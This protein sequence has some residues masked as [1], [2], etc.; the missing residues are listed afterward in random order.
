MT[1]H[2]A[3]RAGCGDT[4]RIAYHLPESDFLRYHI[5]ANEAAGAGYSVFQVMYRRR[6]GLGGRAGWIRTL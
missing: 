5:F 1:H 3:S 6:Y 2:P 4:V